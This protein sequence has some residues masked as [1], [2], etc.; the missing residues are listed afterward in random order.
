LTLQFFP[1]VEGLKVNA[2]LTG[3]PPPG[4]PVKTHVPHSTV[5]WQLDNKHTTASTTPIFKG[6]DSRSEKRDLDC[7]GIEFLLFR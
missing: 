4:L 1:H 7:I 3:L 6:S 5:D 2:L